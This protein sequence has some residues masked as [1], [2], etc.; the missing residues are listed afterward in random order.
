MKETI[1]LCS[2]LAAAVFCVQLLLCR[3]AVRRSVKLIPLFIILAL[4]AAALLLCLVDILDGGGGV[5]IWMIFA[6][7]LSVANTVALAASAAAW[8]VYKRTQK[9]KM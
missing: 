2:I 4:Y 9:S 3:K 1:F 6:Y 8:A 5:A 7:I